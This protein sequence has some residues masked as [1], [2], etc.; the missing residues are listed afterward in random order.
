MSNEPNVTPEPTGTPAAS[1][2]GM[3]QISE[4]ELAELKN[5]SSQYEKIEQEATALDFESV[6]DYQDFLITKKAEELDQ[7]ATATPQATPTPQKLA[8]PT[9]QQVQA[10]MTAAEVAEYNKKID[11]SNVMSSAS[12]IESQFV[13]REMAQAKLPGEQQ[14]KNTKTEIYDMIRGDDTASMVRARAKKHGGNLCIAADKILSIQ[15]QLE[16]QEA[17]TAPAAPIAPDT[18]QLGEGIAPKPEPKEGEQSANEVAA[19]DICPDED[20]VVLT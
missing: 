3:A 13:L 6:E 14:S 15:K 9:K 20:F 2:E 19:D 8:T 16:A 18:T 10:G 5:R 11:D 17:G 7:G 1:A 4:A 12:F